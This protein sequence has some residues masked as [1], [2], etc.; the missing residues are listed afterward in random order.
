MKRIL[1]RLID[2]S[3]IY[4]DNESDNT[5]I[6][7]SNGSTFIVKKSGYDIEFDLNYKDEACISVKFEN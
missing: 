1:I 5:C 7:L 3:H 2:V 4:V 6:E